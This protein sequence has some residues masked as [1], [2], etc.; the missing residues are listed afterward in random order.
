[1]AKWLFGAV[2]A[3]GAHF[4]ASYIIPLDQ[5][6]Q[7]TFAG[8][9][10]WFWPWAHGNSGPLGTIL[11]SGFPVPGFFIA[12]TAAGLF[13]LAALAFVG[14]WV[15]FIWWRVCA[16]AGALISLFLMLMFFGPTKII[17]IALDIFVLW[18]AW[19]NWT[20]AAIH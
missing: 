17:P 3:L 8:L 11:P 12:V 10:K 1:M 18:A 19:N 7:E 4:A 2:L 9:M 16:F 13:I 5:K 15:P 20:L 14:I 6:G